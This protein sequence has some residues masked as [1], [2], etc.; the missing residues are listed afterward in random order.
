MKKFIGVFLAVM[1]MVA[2]WIFEAA[3][4]STAGEVYTYGQRQQG[5]P[6][7]GLPWL[8]QA[9]QAQT[10]QSQ[11]PI[12]P[13]GA[14][15]LTYDPAQVSSAPVATEP[16]VRIVTKYVPVP[17]ETEGY[18]VKRRDTL[19]EI[20]VAQN[21][22][23]EQLLALNQDVTDKHFIRVGQKLVLPV[24]A[25][26]TKL[27]KAE[28]ANKELKAANAALET[29][30]AELLR[31][32]E[33]IKQELQGANEDIASLSDQIIDT[34]GELREA[35]KSAEYFRGQVEVLAK[36]LASAKAEAKANLEGKQSAEKEVS[37]LQSESSLLIWILFAL[38]ILFIFATA[39]AIWLAIRIFRIQAMLAGG[40]TEKDKKDTSA[41]AVEAK[42]AEVG[43]VS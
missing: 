35:E 31:Q 39:V 29:N 12:Q 9:N 42:E 20:A 13:Q 40:K 32:V 4:F 10:D 21:A 14:R 26:R 1:A 37:A 25:N 19:S 38:G 16:A 28:A 2:V 17:E 8:A 34:Q 23:T 7:A 43:Q 15:K 24:P 33:E 18:I 11:V 5:T 22:S 41:Q 36:E 27:A 30:K 6:V 3:A